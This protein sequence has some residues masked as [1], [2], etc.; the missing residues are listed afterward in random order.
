[1]SQHTALIRISISL[2]LIAEILS[3]LVLIGCSFV[4]IAWQDDYYGEPNHQFKTTTGVAHCKTFG[5]EG[6]G[7]GP[8]NALDS[9]AAWCSFLA[10]VLGLTAFFT[11]LSNS[12]NNK[13][14]CAC[15]GTGKRGKIATVAMLFVASIC[16]SLTLLVLAAPSCS[17]EY[18][19]ECQ[20]L[21]TGFISIVCAPLWLLCATLV[22]KIP[23]REDDVV[24]VIQHAE[25]ASLNE[26]EPSNAAAAAAAVLEKSSSKEQQQQG[27][28]DFS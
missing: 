9:I 24:V 15:C 1:M 10:T 20:L 14:G 8:T 22:S 26:V 7:G 25:P 16:Q 18:Q 6:F 27:E 21:S 23:I 19:G 17:D 4:S 12:T 11:L 5:L 3:I 2:V 13:C 28:S